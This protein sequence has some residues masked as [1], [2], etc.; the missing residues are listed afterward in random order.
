MLDAQKQGPADFW[1]ALG[2]D[3]VRLADRL[4]LEPGWTP[5][6]VNAR[7]AGLH[8]MDYSMAPVTWSADGVAR[9]SLYVFTPRKEGKA[10]VDVPGMRESID[11]ARERRERRIGTA[12]ETQKSRKSAAAARE[13]KE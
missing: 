13:A 9:Q 5:A 10:L 4:S 3:F 12:K 2:Y 6:E 1:V 7:L 11:K 8:G